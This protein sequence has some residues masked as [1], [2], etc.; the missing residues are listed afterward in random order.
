VEHDDKEL[1][2]Q[3]IRSGKSAGRFGGRW[4]QG[5]DQRHE[6]SATRGGWWAESRRLYAPRDVG[7]TLEFRQRGHVKVA[8]KHIAADGLVSRGGYRR[9][10]PD[11]TTPWNPEW[12]EQTRHAAESVLQGR[13]LRIFERAFL[14]PVIRGGP[15]PPLRQIAEAEGVPVA[16]ISRIKYD[17]TKE[18]LAALKRGLAAESIDAEPTA[19]NNRGSNPFLYKDMADR[20][21]DA[22]AEARWRR[23]ELELLDRDLYEAAVFDKIVN[24]SAA[25]EQLYAEAFAA[26]HQS[27]GK[28]VCRTAM[29]HEFIDRLGNA[30]TGAN[31]PILAV[32]DAFVIVG[33]QLRS[34]LPDCR[35]G[36]VC[37][38]GGPDL[39]DHPAWNF[40]F[41]PPW[42]RPL[43]K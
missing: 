39:P 4:N 26:R 43:L 15:T 35:R 17:V 22:Q 10:L 40:R 3:I 29:L 42:R 37:G 1:P 28:Y 2:E 19:S 5:F 41:T 30:I 13:D 16:R 27:H 24:R 34:A 11:R 25:V 31:D 8:G 38:G 33:W 12:E 36:C 18:V 32:P 9:I 21:R 7:K 14:E 6:R 20:K 23:W